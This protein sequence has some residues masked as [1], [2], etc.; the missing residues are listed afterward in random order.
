L[1]C[2]TPVPASNNIIINNNNRHRTSRKTDIKALKRR[3]ISVAYNFFKAVSHSS[4]LQ[5]SSFYSPTQVDFFFVLVFDS[6]H[7]R[8][9]R[10]RERERLGK[11]TREGEDEKRERRERV[12]VR[13]SLPSEHTLLNLFFMFYFWALK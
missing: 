10:E 8:K 6:A 12:C 1:C 9:R 3:G 7:V 2:I 5:K 13:E 11:S 4:S